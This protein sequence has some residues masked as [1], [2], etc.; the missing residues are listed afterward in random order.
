MDDRI[1]FI[2]DIDTLVK[3]RFDYISTEIDLNA[4][5]KAKLE[6]KLREYF[7]EYVSEEK[8]TAYA[9][10]IDGEIVSAA[11]LIID[12]KPPGL[13]NLNGRYGT[14]MNV[15]TYPQHRGKG[16]AS[17][18]MS[19]LIVDADNIFITVLDLYSTKAGKRLYE[20]LGFKEIEYSAMRY[21]TNE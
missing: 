15:F 13:N 3:L 20:K 17:C 11:F 19:S 4:E 10:E 12:E 5:D 6:P 7:K 2:T 21:Y 16:Y 1:K 14:I 18:V 9:M 8:F